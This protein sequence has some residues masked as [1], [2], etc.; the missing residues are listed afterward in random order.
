MDTKKN[1]RVNE[2]YVM[3]LNKTYDKYKDVSI[4]RRVEEKESEEKEE[5][6]VKDSS[7]A[8]YLHNKF[9]ESPDS[10]LDDKAKTKNGGILRREWKK[11]Y[12]SNPQLYKT[13][14]FTPDEDKIIV[15]TMR[16]AKNKSE[17]LLELKKVLNRP[18]RSIAHRIEKL[19]TGSVQVVFKLFSREEDFLIIDNSL[20]SLK[21]SKSISATQLV[22]REEL[23]KSLNRNEKS[24]FNRWNYKLK[25]WLLSFYQKTL[26][27][28]IR[29][30]LINVLAEN[31]YSIRDINWDWVLKIPEFSGYTSISLRRVFFII[32][33]VR[34]AERLKINRTEM[35][36]QTIAETEFKF[37]NRPSESSWDLGT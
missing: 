36:L 6:F 5:T 18:Y 30:M 13:K 7:H 2:K 16:S 10:N 19:E 37:R 28:E 34:M 22:D 29:P 15:Q 20:Q 27:L 26:N 35:T 9:Q 11:A 31:F 25:V 32:R 3:L 33:I 12:R 8:K 24:V 17:G 14:R 23:A 1:Y 21:L 4:L